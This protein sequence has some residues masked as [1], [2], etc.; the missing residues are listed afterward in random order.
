MWLERG[1]IAAEDTRLLNSPLGLC[2][3]RALGT[4]WFASHT[5]WT[6]TLREALL[7]ASRAA[8]AGGELAALSGATSPDA[9]LIVVRVLAP[10]IEPLFSLLCA[11][12]A[13][14]RQI[15]WQLGAE[16]PRVWRT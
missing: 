1:R 14:W 16:T 15:V 7:D 5:P 9:R 10:R 12:R 3:Q 2:G 4:V 6:P 11:V 13:A 8:W